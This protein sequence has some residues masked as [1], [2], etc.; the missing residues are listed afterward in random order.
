[1]ADGAVDE[2]FYDTYSDK[3]REAGRLDLPLMLG[4]SGAPFRVAAIEGKG[5]GVVMK[6]A[7]RKGQ[8]LL[9]EPPFL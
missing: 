4:L 8:V 2:G 1:M 6:A 3:S 7:A 9:N 5:K